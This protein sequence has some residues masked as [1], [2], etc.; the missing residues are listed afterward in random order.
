V[1]G[2]L[3]WANLP[4]LW[5]KRSQTNGELETLPVP[6]QVV[7]D[8]QE[9]IA[10]HTNSTRPMLRYAYTERLIYVP[11]HTAHCGEV[12]IVIVMR[13]SLVPRPSEG[14]G[15][16][17]DESLTIVHSVHIF[18]VYIFIAY[19]GVLHLASQ[20]SYEWVDTACLKYLSTPTSA[21]F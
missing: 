2:S 6:D 1:G 9:I 3:K 21:T 5:K 11:H 17:L 4:R 8:A 16:R 10:H 12:L 19:T 18:I 14:L 15:T 7:L 20:H 13:A